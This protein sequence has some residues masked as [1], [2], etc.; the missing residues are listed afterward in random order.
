LAKGQHLSAYQQKIVS[1]YYNN[2]DTISLQKLSEAV[3]ELYLCESDKKAERLWTSVE[4]A[5]KNAKVDPKQILA[6]MATKDVRAL[7]EM[8]NSLAGKK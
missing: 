6:L 8:V 5:L 3:G 1:R 2:I 7:A 4:G